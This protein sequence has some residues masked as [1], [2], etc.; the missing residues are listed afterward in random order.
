MIA[1]HTYKNAHTRMLPLIQSK[2][3]SNFPFFFLAVYTYAN[4]L[5]MFGVWN[6]TQQYTKKWRR[7]WIVYIDQRRNFLYIKLFDY[8]RLC[9]AN[10]FLKKLSESHS[11]AICRSP[12]PTDFWWAEQLEMKRKKL[13]CFGNSVGLI[14]FHFNWKLILFSLSY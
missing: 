5:A 8:F 3:T 10:K 12:L 11:S 4:L 1:S 14:C 6:D 13:V 9:S 7:T 2:K